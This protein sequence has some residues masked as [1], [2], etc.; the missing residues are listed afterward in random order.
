[1]NILIII[2]II[3]IILLIL[4]CIY[5][6]KIENFKCYIDSLNFQTNCDT[7]FPILTSQ[8]QEIQLPQISQIPEI[9][10]ISTIQVLPNSSK[11]MKNFLFE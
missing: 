9:P 7:T 1:M 4:N 2:I 10:P 8:I 3:I 11:I 6:N 5:F